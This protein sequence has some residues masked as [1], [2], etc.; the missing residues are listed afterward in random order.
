MKP[1]IF[2]KSHEEM[3]LRYYICVFNFTMS[4]YPSEKDLS[5]LLNL[6][7]ILILK[8][9]GDNSIKYIRSTYIYSVFKRSKC[10]SLFYTNGRVVFV[11]IVHDTLI[12]Y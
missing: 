5:P 10:D 1:S 6:T 8:Y 3:F 11:V 4:C 2:F 9:L 12:I 7:R